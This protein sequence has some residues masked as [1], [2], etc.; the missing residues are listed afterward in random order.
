MNF[1]F[2]FFSCSKMYVLSRVCQ[3]L[4][5]S[6]FS[7]VG[8]ERQKQVVVAAVGQKVCATKRL[9]VIPFLYS[10]ISLFIDWHCFYRFVFR[11]RTERV[12]E[13]S[14]KGLLFEAGSGTEWWIAKAAV[15]V[16]RLW[17]LGFNGFAVIG[18]AA[19][20]ERKVCKLWK[21]ESFASNNSLW[22]RVS[23]SCSDYDEIN[24]ERNWDVKWNHV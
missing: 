8:M 17:E 21:T 6:R 13:A 18:W 23:R 10:L 12:A 20:S 3:K 15:R 7:V 1:S 5:Q 2:D 14:D 4:S 19:M 16:Q 24:V 22:E 11:G 9:R